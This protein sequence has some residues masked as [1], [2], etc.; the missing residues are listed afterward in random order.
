MRRRQANHLGLSGP[1][2]RRRRA[3]AGLASRFVWRFALGLAFLCLI[4]FTRFP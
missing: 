4:F 2:T 1:F 3:G